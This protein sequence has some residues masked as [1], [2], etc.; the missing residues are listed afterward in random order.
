MTPTSENE[1]VSPSPIGAKGSE[2]QGRGREAASERSVDQNRGSMNKNR[3]LRRQGRKSG[4]KTAKSIPIKARQR[5]VG[6]RARN[7]GGLTWGDLGVAPTQVGAERAARP[8]DR[9]REVSRAHSSD[10]SGETRWSEGANGA[11]LRNRVKGDGRVS[12]AWP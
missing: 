9:V 7:G 5:K 4:Q 6:D 10:E 12:P 11:I 3:L 1:R 2:A 8:A